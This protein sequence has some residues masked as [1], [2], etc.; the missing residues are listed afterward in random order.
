MPSNDWNDGGRIN[1]FLTH[2]Q[3]KMERDADSFKTIQQG[4]Q[5]AQ[6]LTE[7]L[8]KN[9]EM[10]GVLERQLGYVGS[11]DLLMKKR[12]P[13]EYIKMFTPEDDGEIGS[14]LREYKPAT[15]PWEA[16]GRKKV[17]E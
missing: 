4:Q 16:L 2:A 3:N 13:Q 1:R 6:K 9:P 17:L 15:S 12:S 11:E 10:A 7:F 8:A 14:F 5:D